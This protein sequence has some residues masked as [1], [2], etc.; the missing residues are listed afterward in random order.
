[1]NSRDGW[2]DKW[3]WVDTDGSM[4]GWIDPGV[5]MTTNELSM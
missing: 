1:M 3:I 2:M 4:G 5:A